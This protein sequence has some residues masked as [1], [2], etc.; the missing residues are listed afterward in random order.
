MDVF[1]NS[2]DLPEEIKAFS[3]TKRAFTRDATDDG[4]M[5]RNTDLLRAYLF[6]CLRVCFRG[7]NVR[8]VFLPALSY[9]GKTKNSPMLHSVIVCEMADQAAAIVTDAQTSSSFLELGIIRAVDDG[10]R[11][12]DFD[13]VAFVR[14]IGAG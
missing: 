2:P 3:E 6:H 9:L 8:S 5:G 1:L 7:Q 14:N 11:P 12:F 4:N 10:L 13:P